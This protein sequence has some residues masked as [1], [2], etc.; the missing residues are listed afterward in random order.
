MIETQPDIYPL[1]GGP[2]IAKQPWRPLPGY[3]YLRLLD[4]E[5]T[6]PSGLILPDGAV[7]ATGDAEVLAV[8]AG[9]LYDNGIRAVPWSFAGDRV[10]VDRRTVRWIGIGR[11]ART[12]F[13]REE[14]LVAEIAGGALPLNDWVLIAPDPAPA[15]LHGLEIPEDQ[16]AAPRAGCVLV[17]G[18]GRVRESGPYAGS[19]RRLQP[20]FP[21]GAR[22]RWAR[23]AQTCNAWND[24]ANG[25][26]FVRYD[27]LIA[28][29][30]G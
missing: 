30:E 1:H 21:P 14:D 3:Y 25:G 16:R 29:E 7:S 15:S 2:L 11:E 17:V 12:G 8:G 23:E 24:E 9:R 4:P 27:D 28:I 26:R 18:P 22:V 5:Q 10:L 20:L 13:V 19:R 6:L